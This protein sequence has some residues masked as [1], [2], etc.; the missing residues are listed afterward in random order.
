M[1]LSLSIKNFTLVEQLHVDFESGMTAITGETGTGKSLVLD[2]LGIALGDR[3]DTGKIRAGRDKL[4][5]TAVFSVA[6]N[7]RARD[8]LASHEFDDDGGECIIR[9]TLSTE[10]RSR[11]F[12]NGQPVP[13]QQLQELGDLML[14]IH[15]QHEHQSL[16]V[17]DTHRRL[18][19]AFAG[20]E[21]LARQVATAYR[22]WQSAHR[23][24][25]ER[26]EN[27]RENDARRDFVAFQVSEF[28]E[29]ALGDGELKELEREQNLLANAEQI[30]G[31]CHRI[32]AL[33]RD[34][35]GSDA[36]SLLS[37]AVHLLEAL[38]EKSAGLREAESMLSSAL[39]QLEEAGREIQHHV[40]SYDV[41]PER[42][43]EVEERLSQIY[44]LARKHKTSPDE[45]ASRRDELE[46]ELERLSGSEASLEA[47]TERVT[48]LETELT[49]LE[50]KLTAD[51]TR[52]TSA[53]AGLVNEQ[54]AQLGMAAASLEVRISPLR[55]HGPH[56]AESVEFLVSTNP[57]QKPGSLN[58]IASGGELS[59]IS[60][61][62]QVIAAR[63]TEIPTLVFDEV[64]VGVGGAVAEVIGR[65]LRGLGG[66]GQVISVTHL[67]Q[68]ASCAHHHL[69]A[70]KST[71]GKTTASRLEALSEENRVQEIARMLGGAKIT[72]NTLGHAEEMLRL[73]A[74]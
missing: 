61:A 33:C 67:P 4:D 32:L 60:L 52:A 27:S 63:H 42:L 69:V 36:Q 66:N 18:L 12:I 51:R 31:D 46:A 53:F 72:K 57:G 29:L 3:G 70:S 17:R 55:D 40:D 35:D 16:L 64:D 54:L 9:R 73:S 56:G 6:N 1:L 15:S 10:G 30:L 68:V 38:P 5:V 74:G 24:L 26:R 2:A 71:D 39:I 13:M 45:L 37:R 7:A 19:D 50:K 11:G 28:E 14:D 25:A 21:A 59:R 22:A 43:R 20:S 65:L 48:A 49:A 34:G 8:W 62:I 58:K 41:N 47:L 23:E 44:Q